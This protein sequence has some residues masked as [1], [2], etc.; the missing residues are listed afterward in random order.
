M[1]VIGDD[2][3]SVRLV[4]RYIASLQKDLPDSVPALNEVMQHVLAV[5]EIAKEC[6]ARDGSWSEYYVALA[7]CALRGLHLGYAFAR[8]AAADVLPGGVVDS[9]T[10]QPRHADDG[11]RADHRFSQRPHGTELISP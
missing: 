11:R 1:P 9:R 5:R 3:W 8:R 10:A 2:W 7:M 4:L 6:L